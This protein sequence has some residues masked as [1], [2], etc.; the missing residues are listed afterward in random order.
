VF[1]IS[2]SND[3]TREVSE[4]G[5][6]RLGFGEGGVAVAWGA[7]VERGPLFTLERSFSKKT[8][9]AGV[10]TPE[11]TNLSTGQSPR[12]RNHNDHLK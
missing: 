11:R 12:R 3:E 10:V 4:E 7:T 2:D 9:T 5:I 8:L 6:T 1:P